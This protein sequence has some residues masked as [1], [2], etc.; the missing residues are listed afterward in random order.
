MILAC[1]AAAL[2]L[3]AAADPSPGSPGWYERETANWLDSSGRLRDQLSDP[4]YW[5]LR[6]SHED[7]TNADPYRAPETW[8][9]SRGRVM[10]VHYP[11]RYG[12]MISAHLWAPPAAFVDPVTHRRFRGPYPAA[13]FLNGAGDS[14]EEYWSFAQDLAEH[15]YIVMTFDPQGAGASEDAPNPES[16]YC[17][18]NGSWRKPQEMGVREHG[19]CAG[20]N[21][22]GVNSTVG[23]VPAVAAIAI[24]GRTGSQGTTDVQ[25]LYEE[26]EPNFVFGALDAWRWLAS[27]A[28]PWRR[29][30]DFRRVGLIGHSL[31][32]YAAALVA[33]GDPR[34]R[35]RAAVAMDSYGAFMHGVHPTVPTLYE[36]SEQELFS[37]PRLAAPPPTAL[38]ATRRDYAAATR[39]HIPAMYTVLRSSTHQE[40][41]YVGPEAGQPASRYGQRVATYFALAW[42]DRHLKGRV[43]G[44]RRGDETLQRRNAI[45]RLRAARFDRS[46]DRSSIG[47]GV[48]DLV[49]LTNR[50]YLIGNAAIAEAL[51]DYYV[52][53]YAF[54]RFSCIDMRRAC[55]RTG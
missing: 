6:L 3:P 18:P 21:D 34:R 7:T 14:E 26:L 16:T 10:A 55:T 28:N 23:Q 53:R 52:S 35:F 54:D 5:A 17:D 1:V 49:A 39:R 47:L 9:P 25:S 38:H 11:N 24:D 27:R 44:H 31:G 43:P 19:S 45:R 20:Q 13:I 8:A 41:A 29:L 15:G 30:I 32:A 4:R 37:G 36:Q 40:F 50:P 2:L 42:F 46:V 51:S 48:W 12:A 33:N 22:N